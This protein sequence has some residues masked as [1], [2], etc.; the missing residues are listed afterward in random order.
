[1]QLCRMK[2]KEYL[3]GKRDDTNR[4]AHSAF[5]GGIYYVLDHQL[6]RPL[7]PQPQ[8]LL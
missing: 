3:W 7:Y 6:L 5:Y 8:V 4:P 2:N 1:M